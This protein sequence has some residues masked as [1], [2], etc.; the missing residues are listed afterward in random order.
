VI[1]RW[2][3][4]Q[5]SG[6]GVNDDLARHAEGAAQNVEIEA[7]ELHDEVLRTPDPLDRLLRDMRDQRR[8]RS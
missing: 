8:D 3:F 1:L 2:I 4:D 7:S 6:R 5:L